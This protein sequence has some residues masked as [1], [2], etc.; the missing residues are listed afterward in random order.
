MGPPTVV[1][2]PSANHLSAHNR[3]FRRKYVSDRRST[4]HINT[5]SAEAVLLQSDLHEGLGLD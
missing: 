1:V 4:T 5:N 2:E 3:S